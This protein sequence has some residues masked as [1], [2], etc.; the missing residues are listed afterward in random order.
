MSVIQEITKKAM[1]LDELRKTQ[2]WSVLSSAISDVVSGIE[3][4]ILTPNSKSNEVLFTKHDLLRVQREMLLK[5]LNAP[6]EE[7]KRFLCEI[8]SAKQDNSFNI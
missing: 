6:E 3:T 2:G 4:D 7:L 1:A 5:F 8:E